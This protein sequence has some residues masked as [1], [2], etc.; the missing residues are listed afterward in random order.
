VES[1]SGEAGESWRRAEEE[2]TLMWR[3]RG[4]AI[5]ENER[6]YGTRKIRDP[7]TVG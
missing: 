3:G 5:E 2:G 6:R 4:R 1:I 7:K